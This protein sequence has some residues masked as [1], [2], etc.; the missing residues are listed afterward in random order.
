MASVDLLAPK[1]FP[2]T[3]DTLQ[4]TAAK[5]G[6]R[7]PD[8][9]VNEF[10]E[11]LASARAAMEEVLAI[12]DFMPVPEV[13]K[14]PRNDVMTVSQEENPYNAW[15]TKVTVQNVDKEELDVG[16][17]AG[18]RIVLKDNVCLAGVPC[19]FGTDVFSDWIP[20]TDA[21]VVTR[22]LEAGGT[23]RS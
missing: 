12:D 10:T 7:I 18:K 13:T 8:N 9:K 17:L 2:V 5:I 15:A 22:I 1:E 14:Y 6:V 20:K 19:H 3:P 16:I 4:Q 21:T 11:M 23:V